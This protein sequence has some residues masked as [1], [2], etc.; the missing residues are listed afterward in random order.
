MGQYDGNYKQPLSM[1]G[2]HRICNNGV[3][4]LP[5]VD[6][7]SQCLHLE[8]VLHLGSMD[9]TFHSMQQHA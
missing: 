4:W 7:S 3:N 8:L 9:A 2:V 5:L 6:R 1:L